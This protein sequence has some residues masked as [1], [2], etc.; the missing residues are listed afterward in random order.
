MG[1]FGG[2]LRLKVV[3]VEDWESEDSGCTR[4]TGGVG[5]APRLVED[6]ALS[7]S[8]LS[9]T[10]LFRFFIVEALPK[11]RLDTWNSNSV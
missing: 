7:T 5:R 10:L 4:L 1:R 3:A 8:L 9:L 2:N 11:A 6:E